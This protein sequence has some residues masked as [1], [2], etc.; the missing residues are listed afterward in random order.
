VATLG[1]G[2]FFGEAALITGEPRNAT[3]VARDDV[4]LYELK[5]EDFM[6]A[7]NASASFNEQ[8]RDVFFKRSRS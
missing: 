7:L 1:V 8:L 6:A 4:V 2:D 3:V 5:K